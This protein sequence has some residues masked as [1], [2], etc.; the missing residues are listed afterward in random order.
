MWETVMSSFYDEL[1]KLGAPPE[2][3]ISA[4]PP[5]KK[6]ERKE[7]IR[8]RLLRRAKG[9]AAGSLPTAAGIRYLIPAKDVGK[10]VMRGLKPS[11]HSLL[12][13]AGGVGAGVLG[14]ALAHKDSK[15][16]RVI[17]QL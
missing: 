17:V 15:P 11:T 2:L 7:R 8:E 13:A 3:I 10:G 4:A 16:S 9:F 14:A 12:Q 5:P 6:R 1:E